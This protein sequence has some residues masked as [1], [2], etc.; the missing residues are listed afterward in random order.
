MAHHGQAVAFSHSRKIGFR[1]RS[2]LNDRI[3]GGSQ[4][5]KCL[6]LVCTWEMTSLKCQEGALQ[7]TLSTSE[8]KVQEMQG[9]SQLYTQFKEEALSA[10]CLFVH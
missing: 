6:F 7:K 3:L 8:A 10:E 5:Y 4:T 2:H 9:D 1:G